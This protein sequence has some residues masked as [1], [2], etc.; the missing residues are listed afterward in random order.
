[1]R[2]WS[3]IVCL[4][5]AAGLA[6]G[7]FVIDEIEA[8]QEIMD[9][10]R[11]GGAKAEAEEE[12]APPSEEGSP[13]LVAKVKD[14]W[15]GL[16]AD[17]GGSPQRD[18]GPPPHPDDVLGTCDLGGSLTFMRKFDCQRKGGEFKPRKG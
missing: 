7:C 8:G 6:T 10:H 14:W 15:A 4:I 9:Q 13:G 11:P 16:G 1:M 3:A 18:S 5:A 17:S 2:R 12:A